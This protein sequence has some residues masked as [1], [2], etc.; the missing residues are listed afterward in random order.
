[1]QTTYTNLAPEGFLGLM[2]EDFT[3][4]V[5][6]AIP[7]VSV[8]IGKLLVGDKT[9]GKPR[10]AVKYPGAAADI[11]TKAM[12]AGI[13]V[14]DQSR[15]GGVD[16]PALRPT[17]LLRRGRIWVIAEGAA[18]RYTPC[19]IRYVAGAGGTE[20]GSFRGDVDTAS[21]AQ[22]DWA[23]FLTDAPAGSLALV[24]VSIF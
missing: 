13:T 12:L 24:E 20:L 22:C 19:F 14:W 21:A 3:R 8:K 15:E 5:D 16:W 6:T 23:I 11:T 10:G 17:P 7:Q 4:F 2:T 1:M 9:A 18:A